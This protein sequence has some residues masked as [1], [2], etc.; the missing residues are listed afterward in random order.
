MVVPASVTTMGDS[1]FAYCKYLTSV[2]FTNIT[3]IGATVFYETAKLVS[4]VFPTTLLSI[5]GVANFQGCTSLTMIVIPSSVTV[6]S[7]PLTFNLC[8][9]LTTVMVPSLDIFQTTDSFNGTE[10]KSIVT[11]MWATSLNPYTFPA[12]Y[13]PASTVISLLRK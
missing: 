2:E 3:T 6:I 13:Q 10:A 8:T 5:T 4:V 12:G 7:G 9:K 1:T 11:V